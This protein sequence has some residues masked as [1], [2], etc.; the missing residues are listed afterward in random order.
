LSRRQNGDGSL[1]S[2]PLHSDFSLGRVKVSCNG[3]TRDALLNFCSL[4]Y[5][6]GRLIC[7]EWIKKCVATLSMKIHHFRSFAYNEFICQFF[8][9]SKGGR[10]FLCRL[11]VVSTGGAISKAVVGNRQECRKLDGLL[12]TGRNHF[13]RYPHTVHMASLPDRNHG[14][15]CRLVAPA[16]AQHR[17]LEELMHEHRWPLAH[18]RIYR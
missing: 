2:R 4:L 3:N 16:S 5:L 17:A 10:G 15:L 6:I 8:R 13:H 11:E 14:A 18:P 9:L 7:S 12:G 1:L